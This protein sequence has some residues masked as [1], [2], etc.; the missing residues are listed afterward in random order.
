MATTEQVRLERIGFHAL[1]LD[2]RISQSLAGAKIT[3]EQAQQYRTRLYKAEHIAARPGAV[4][5]QADGTYAVK[6][7]NATCQT[8][9]RVADKQCTCPDFTKAELSICKHTFAALLTHKACCDLKRLAAPATEA[10]PTVEEMLA[11]LD[12]R[13]AQLVARTEQYEAAPVCTPKAQPLPEAP[14]SVNVRLVICGREV[15]FTLR[16]TDEV[17]LEERL[18]ALLERH[19]KPVYHNGQEH[20]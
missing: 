3:P 5:R 20:A 19:P 15:Q 9:Y 14:A 18:T 17:R 8:I 13:E 1:D 11:E 7:D 16:D 12:E 4:T 2:M 6:S 10:E